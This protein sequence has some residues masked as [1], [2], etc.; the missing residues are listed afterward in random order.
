MERVLFEVTSTS[1][2]TA[3]AASMFSIT[4]WNSLV[5]ATVIHRINHETEAT[6]VAIGITVP[7]Q[8]NEELDSLDYHAG[9][10]ETSSML[11]LEPGLVR[12]DK[13]TEAGHT[14]HPTDGRAAGALEE[15][16]RLESVW[17]RYW[18]CRRDEKGGASNELSSK[19]SLSLRDP[20]AAKAEIGKEMIQD[21]VD[22]AVKFIE[23][24]NKARAR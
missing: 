24:W 14:F 7:F 16:P 23:A 10:E 3:F 1:S 6:A 8:K 18:A 22:R 19:R 12:M 21:M 9:V 20:R 13:A 17:G 11:Y 5:E 4:T 2:S 15:E